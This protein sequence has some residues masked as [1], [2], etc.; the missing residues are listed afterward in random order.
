MNKDKFGLYASL[1]TEQINKNTQD[2]DRVSL[3]EVLIKLN[4]E[5]ITVPKAVGK[6]IKNIASGAKLISKAF[7]NGKNIFFIGAGTSGRLGVLEA[8]ELPP[9]YGVEP[10]RFTAIMAGGEKAVFMSKEGAED[11]YEDGK[12]EILKRAKKGDIVIGIAASGVTP[13]VQGAMDAA[14]KKGAKTIF[15]TCNKK[16]KPKSAQVIIAADVGP[17]PINGSTRMKSGTATKLI[18]NML[19]TSAMVISGKVYKNWMVDLKKTSFKL[20]MRCERITAQICGISPKEAEK[21]LKKT[22]YRV[23]EAIVVCKLKTDVKKAALLLK[24]HKGFLKDI[25][26]KK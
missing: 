9:T 18:L 17:E 20:K 25:I 4:R 3:E 26:E 12:K 8:S 19:T 22:D 7:L 24:K 16:S 11:I 14:I 23:K 2:I 13:Y 5:D 6:E 21:I 1:P 10:D 15:V